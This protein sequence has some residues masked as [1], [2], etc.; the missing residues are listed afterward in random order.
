MPG[1][2][3]AYGEMGLL[4]LLRRSAGEEGV[5]QYECRNCGKNLSAEPDE[6]PTCG[7]TEIAEYTV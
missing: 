2:K 1:E 5:T 3:V 4:K 7:S 6:C